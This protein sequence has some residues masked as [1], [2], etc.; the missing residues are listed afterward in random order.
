[1]DCP[2]TVRYATAGSYC[3]PAPCARIHFLVNQTLGPAPVAIA[4][5][6]TSSPRVGLFRGGTGNGP[7]TTVVNDHA[8]G[9]IFTRAS[10]TLLA[11]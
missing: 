1:M 4:P 3:T 8:L 2:H 6:A 7:M 10:C 11:R 5:R 9:M